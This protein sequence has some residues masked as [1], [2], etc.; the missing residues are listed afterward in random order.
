MTDTVAERK[1]D[2]NK[3]YLNL[4]QTGEE[5]ADKNAAADLL[6]E[7]KKTVLSRLVNE[8]QEKSHAAKE[9][10]AM[11]HPDYLAHLESMVEARRHA[12]RAR[13][14]YDAAKALTELRRSE[15]STRRSEMNLR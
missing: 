4:V 6:E 15:E 9:S 1:L 10:Q 3:A 5:W 7:T 13:V 14:R 11:T 8:S 12:N 2:S